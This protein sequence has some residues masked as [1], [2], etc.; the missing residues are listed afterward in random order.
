[1][2]Q[3]RFECDEPQVVGGIGVLKGCDVMVNLEIR[4]DLTLNL[5][6]AE[7]TSQLM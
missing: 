6:L 5:L 3:M 1:M 2:R 7:K 4:T